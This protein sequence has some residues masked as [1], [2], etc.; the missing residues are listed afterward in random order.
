MD[1]IDL[2]HPRSNTECHNHNRISPSP[3]KVRSSS[4]STTVDIFRYLLNPSMNYIKIYQ[5]ESIKA[6][7][8]RF[9]Y[10]LECIDG[11]VIYIPR[12]WKK[13]WLLL[14]S[15]MPSDHGAWKSFL[16]CGTNLTNH[17][18]N[19]YNKKKNLL[20]MERMQRK[21]RKCN[22]SKLF[23]HYY[24]GIYKYPI[25]SIFDF[26]SIEFSFFEIKNYDSDLHIFRKAKPN[27]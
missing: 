8:E 19:C 16:A 5:G 25:Y 3:V 10:K 13:E 9:Y 18:E 15:T 26:F 23:Y 14:L 27:W 21:F 2:I 20:I 24:H 1:V 7:I 4:F 6:W 22:E 11:P 17:H 12:R